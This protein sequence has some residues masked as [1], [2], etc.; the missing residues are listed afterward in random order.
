VKRKT[1]R[2]VSNILYSSKLTEF[3]TYTYRRWIF[4]YILK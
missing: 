2:E 3:D 4:I 1:L